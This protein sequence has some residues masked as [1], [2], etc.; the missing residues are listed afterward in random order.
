MDSKSLRLCLKIPVQKIINLFLNLLFFKK[1]ANL[2]YIY[3][4]VNYDNQYTSINDY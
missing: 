3:Q 4:R 1:E 2:I